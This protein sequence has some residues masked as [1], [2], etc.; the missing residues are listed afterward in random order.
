MSANTTRPV[1]SCLVLQSTNVRVDAA[2]M[3]VGNMTLT[4]Y[5]VD[6]YPEHAM[7]VI[8][9]YSVVINVCDLLPAS[10]LFIGR[11]VSS[12][13]I[14]DIRIYQPLVHQHLD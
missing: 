12:L 10:F 4:S 14:T 9:F 8:M 1:L 3:Q 6:N 5:I 2:G 13:T 11:A 7:E